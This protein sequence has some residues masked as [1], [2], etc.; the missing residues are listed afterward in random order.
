[1]RSIALAALWIASCA[2][3]AERPLVPALRYAGE[4]VSAPSE[5]APFRK[6]APA[7]ES[8]GALPRVAVEPFTLDNGLRGFVVQ[9]HG[10]PMVAA[11]LVLDTADL[12]AGDV[13]GRRAGYL[14]GVFLSPPEG[15]VRTSATCGT[16]GCV[17]A[18][19]GSSDRLGEVL[20]HVTDATLRDGP[21]ALYAQRLASL[22][23]HEQQSVRDPGQSF[24]RIAAALV[25]GNGHRYGQTAP[26]SPPRLEELEALHGRV[27]DP[28]RATLLVVGDVS[29]QDAVAEATR[30]FGAWRAGAPIAASAPEPLPEPAGPRMAVFQVPKMVQVRGALV[31]RGPAA[32]SPDFF[33]FLV[34]GDLLGAAPGSEA[35]EQLR[36]EMTAAYHVESSIERLT[37]V[38][39]MSLGGSFEGEKAVAGIAKLLQTVRAV[40]E[41]GPTPEALERAKR[42]AVAQ[43]RQALATDDGIAGVLG[44]GLLDGLSLEATLDTPARVRA[45][46]AAE[47]QAAA[48]KYLGPAALHVVI[49]GD[50]RF[51]LEARELRL[52]APVPVDGYGQ[53]L[54]AAKA[55]E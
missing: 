28:R 39:V 53:P 38:S 1:M 13:G 31:A 42:L 21:D 5:N 9:R 41:Q 44:A 26:G 46:Q 15:R 34:L 17:I 4:E 2:S 49:V 25:F 48:Q 30:R 40:R 3:P 7:V 29:F 10:F 23:R 27:F 12:E 37:D 33:P 45:V 50:P 6:S 24:A 18:S 11:R 20:G 14:T 36:E 54:A 32:S 35:F 19:R 22:S 52:G 43:W 8:D 47:V 51:L 55:S 16:R